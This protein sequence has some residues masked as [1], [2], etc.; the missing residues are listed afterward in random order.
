[1]GGLAVVV[2][3]LIIIG[4]VSVFKSTKGISELARAMM[5]NTSDSL[6]DALAIGMNEHL[7]TARN[8]SFSNSV[9][10]ASE[11]V[12]RDGEAKSQREIAL[13]DQ[14]L[15]RIKKAEGDRLSSINLVDR[16]GIF[17]ASS[18]AKGFKGANISERDF[19]AKAL[20]G[21]PSVGSVIRSV[22]TG[23]VICTV[24]SPIY[25]SGGR[26][27]TGVV[28]MALEL[29]YLTDIV[30]KIKSGKS[31]Y[32]YVVD[33]DGFYITHPVKDHI[34]KE[35]I[36]R[37]K[38]METVSNLVKQGKP[39]T[40]ECAVDGIR[41]VAVVTPVD[42]A[43]WSLVN[44]IP[45]DELLFSAHSA[46]NVIIVVGFAFLVFGSVFF[47]FFARSISRP[48]EKIVDAAQKIA[49]GDL[50]VNI[51]QTVRHD[52]IGKLAGAFTRMV[53]TL[54]EEALI[55]EEI[56]ANKLSVEV[57]PLSEKDILGNALATM[58]SNMRSQIQEIVEGVDVLASS[59]SEIMASVTQLTSGAAETAAAVA[60]TT[61]TVEEVKQTVE[62]SSQKA[63]NV[64]DLGQRTAEISKAGLKAIEDAQ[65]GMDR[66]KEQMEAITD[67][68]IRLSEQSQAVGEI[69][70]TVG[71]IAEQSNILAVNASI[72]AAKA[73]EQGKGF[74]VVA[75]EMK[76][77]AEQSK[78]STIQVR[79]ILFDVQK[80]ISSSVMATEQGS[81]AVDVGARLSAEAGGSIEALAA[82]VV[83]ATNA[84]IQIA[85][86]SQQQLVGID[87]VVSAMENIR[88]ASTQTAASTK[89]AESVAHGLHTLGQRL[90]EMLG[91]YKL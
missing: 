79:T 7:V 57:T 33:K 6:S 87:Q 82:S 18:E 16:R 17:F 85:A 60:E 20:Q 25:S 41:K 58:V 49:S 42:V 39:G 19:F 51:P 77:L 5:K 27:I 78:K 11:K 1:M 70:S 13:A 84:A 66:I 43:G 56:A 46:R 28:L 55:A 64:V 45:V 72:E 50:S 2:I 71:D 22:V 74:A 88:D 76:S 63:K 83:E 40:T 65:D 15:T 75:Q 86:S 67:M 89:Q 59:A 80:A 73:G 8:V 9:I 24:A 23:R 52:E 36:F 54:K 69:I 90:Q 38:G 53:E 26:E 4:I 12:A 32:A 68:V 21:I 29:R 10:A 34:L 30:D 62:V 48:M 31:G 47:Y 37:I 14:E 61:I 44:T 91:R 35:N 81:K 3:P